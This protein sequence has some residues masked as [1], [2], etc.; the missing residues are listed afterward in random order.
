MPWHL[1]TVRTCAWLCPKALR[2]CFVAFFHCTCKVS[3]LENYSNFSKAFLLSSQSLPIITC[4]FLWSPELR[5]N[6]FI[7]YVF[8]SGGVW[9]KGLWI[10]KGKSLL[11]TLLSYCQATLL[12]VV[13]DTILYFR[14]MKLF[15]YLWI[16]FIFICCFFVCLNPGYQ[17]RCGA[18]E[19]LDLTCV[20]CVHLVNLQ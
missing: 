10:R 12:Y 16:C 14:E 4:H 5:W 19:H 9:V 7:L 15:M 8:V 11:Q 1:T 20:F 2:S 3:V 17:F 13:S 18:A 6:L